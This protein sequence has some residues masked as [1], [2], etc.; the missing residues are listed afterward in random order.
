MVF[1]TSEIQY[2]VLVLTSFVGLRGSACC[3]LFVLFLFFCNFFDGRRW[4]INHSVV[5]SHADG[6]TSLVRYLR[7]SRLG[8]SAT[9]H[10][11]GKVIG[12]V[13][14]ME[15]RLMEKPESSRDVKESSTMRVR[16]DTIHSLNG[17]RG[18]QDPVIRASRH[19]ASHYLCGYTANPKVW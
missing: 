3:C 16:S 19:M 6:L 9:C 7:T 17:S 15:G 2:H 5:G 1:F 4:Q 11:T 10:I 18:Y 14:G 12:K 13:S 8:W